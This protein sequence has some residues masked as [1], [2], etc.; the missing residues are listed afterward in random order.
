MGSLLR[1]YL[2]VPKEQVDDPNISGSINGIPG[3]SACL[4]PENGEKA[5][6]CSED[7]NN[8]DVGN[9]VQKGSVSE[10][11]ITSTQQ[12]KNVVAIV[13][14]PRAGLH[15]TVRII[16]YCFSIIFMLL[17]DCYHICNSTLSRI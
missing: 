17:I 8:A 11:G 16:L 14:P 13:D 7:N 9:A 5:S 10:N 6:I 1:E 4:E 15:P 2:N 12:F 3:D